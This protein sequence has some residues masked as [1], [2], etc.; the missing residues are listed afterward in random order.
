[1]LGEDGAVTADPEQV[2]RKARSAWKKIYDGMGEEEFELVER[3][4]RIYKYD[5]IERRPRADLAE[6]TLRD[7]EYA[8]EQG[9]N[10]AAGADLWKPKELKWLGRGFC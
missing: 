4:F 7:V 1:M 8:V 6:I 9:G 5:M 3:L 10:S 2:D